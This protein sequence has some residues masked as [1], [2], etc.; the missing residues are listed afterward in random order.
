[1]LCGDWAAEVQT[2]RKAGSFCYL[3]Y[4]KTVMIARVQ[5]ARLVIIAFQSSFML[6]CC[7]YQRLLTRRTWRILNI[8]WIQIVISW[9]SFVLSLPNCCFFC[10]CC[11]SREKSWG[12][13]FLWSTPPSPQLSPLLLRS[14]CCYYYCLFSS[15]AVAS[16][17]DRGLPVIYFKVAS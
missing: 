16:L 1:M 12:L 9:I 6:R 2:T 8:D 11:Y 13:F 10:C 3:D 4:R 17:P 15:L 5:H 7:C 14:L